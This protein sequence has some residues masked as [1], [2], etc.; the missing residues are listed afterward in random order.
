MYLSCICTG[1]LYQIKGG[2]TSLKGDNLP[3]VCFDIIRNNSVDNG[4]NA[5][6]IDWALYRVNPKSRE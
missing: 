1:T 4:L 6:Y 2:Y 5:I 3:N